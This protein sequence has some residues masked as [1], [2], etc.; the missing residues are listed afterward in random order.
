[1]SLILILLLLYIVGRVARAAWR[2]WSALPS[3][4]ADFG[5]VEGDTGGRP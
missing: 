1:M 5:L 4:N 3:R 2:L